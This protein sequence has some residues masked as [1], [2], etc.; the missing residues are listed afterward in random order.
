MSWFGGTV[1]GR[2]VLKLMALAC[3]CA[4]W[5]YVDAAVMATKTVTVRATVVDADGNRIDLARDRAPQ[6]DVTVRGPADKMDCVTL[7]SVFC[8]G[9]IADGRT[10]G[11]AEVSFGSGA[12]QLPEIPGLLLVNVEPAATTIELPTPQSTK[13]P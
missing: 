1:L 5:V 3:A 9:R 8:T 12:V 7:Q 4:L 2:L 6:V 13:A 10:S 11:S